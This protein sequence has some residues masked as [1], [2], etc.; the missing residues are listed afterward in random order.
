VRCCCLAYHDEHDYP[1][2]VCAA[3]AAAWLTMMSMII[4]SILCAAVA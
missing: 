1:E 2:H 4:L 3:A